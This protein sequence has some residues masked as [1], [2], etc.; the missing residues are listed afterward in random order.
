MCCQKSIELSLGTD[1]AANSHQSYLY[2]DYTHVCIQDAGMV[3]MHMLRAHAAAY[4][5]IK[6][7]PGVYSYWSGTTI[8]RVL[9]CR[10]AAL[11]SSVA[12]SST[13]G[14]AVCC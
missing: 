11:V 14:C 10:S 8:F 6:Q 4:R 5:A 7:M 1:T 2:S 3:L 13:F 12:S 9:G